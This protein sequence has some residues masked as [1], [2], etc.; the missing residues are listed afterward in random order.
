MTT[1]A[2][3][4]GEILNRVGYGPDRFALFDLWDK[5]AAKVIQGCRAVAL[6][7]RRLCVEV[8]STVH[9][10]ELMYSKDRLIKKVN[11]ALGT[12]MITDIKFELSKGGTLRAKNPK[13]KWNR[14]F[15]K[16]DG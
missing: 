16:R 2:E 10:Q 15:G 7:G 11:Q 9:R 5:E 6:Q 4:V 12:R 8:A 3:A 13:W 1:A 14:S